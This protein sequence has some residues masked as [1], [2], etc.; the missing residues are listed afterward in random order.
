MSPC[1]KVINFQTITKSN[2][3]DRVEAHVRQSNLFRNSK[4]LLIDYKN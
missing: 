4:N 2:I 1:T 3:M